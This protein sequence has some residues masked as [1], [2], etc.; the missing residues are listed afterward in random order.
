VDGARVQDIQLYSRKM[1]IYSSPLQPGGLNLPLAAMARSR[2]SLSVTPPLVSSRN[3]F[4][5]RNQRSRKQP[6]CPQRWPAWRCQR[7]P[8]LFRLPHLHSS[9]RHPSEE[10]SHPT[11]R[12]LDRR[13]DKPCTAAVRSGISTFHLLMS[14]VDQGENE[15]EKTRSCPS[16]SN[17]IKEPG[18]YFT[19]RVLCCP[20]QRRMR[21]S[22]LIPG[23]SI[24]TSVRSYIHT[25]WWNRHLRMSNRRWRH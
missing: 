19:T 9:L 6:H 22:R 3:F 8:R 15:R 5:S 4:P 13:G 14:V 21:R 10:Q 18:H 12:A 25:N 17:S 1:I 23:P 2:K 20:S 7:L 16:T 24:S 11:L